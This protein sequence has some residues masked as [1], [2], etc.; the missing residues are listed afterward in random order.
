MEVTVLPRGPVT[1]AGLY[2][3]GATFKGLRT[4]V[5]A[6]KPRRKRRPNPQAQAAAQ[7]AAYAKHAA[8]EAAGKARV[9]QAEADLAKAKALGMKLG[10]YDKAVKAG[11]I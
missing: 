7:A 4:G 2:P 5:T 3:A 11:L 10:E 6:S 9:A 1:K 8:K